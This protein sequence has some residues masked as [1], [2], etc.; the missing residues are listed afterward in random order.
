LTK[1]LFAKNSQPRRIRD[2]L[3]S[4]TSQFGNRDVETLLRDYT[5][6][7]GF[8]DVSEFQ[9]NGLTQKINAIC[10]NSSIKT[11]DQINAMS[12]ECYLAKRRKDGLSKQTSNHYRQ[13]I[14]QFCRW[15]VKHNYLNANPIS[16]VPKLNVKTDRRH[17]R[18]ALAP[19]EFRRLI[20]AAEAG[21]SIQAIPGVDRAMMYI[22]AAWTG[23]RRGEIGSLKL[24]SLDLESD[25]PTVTVDASFSKRRRKDTQ[26]LH[27]DVSERLKKWLEIRKP[28]HKTLLFPVSKVT[29][30][31]D[32]RTSIMMKRDLAI[33][34]Q[35][36][37]AEAADEA[38]R[39]KRTKSDFLTYKNDDGLFADFHANRHTFITNLGRAGLSAKV[40]QTLA[41]HSDIRLTMNVYSHT[42]LAEQKEAVGRLPQ[43]EIK[44]RQETPHEVENDNQPLEG[45]PQRL[46]Q[47]RHSNAQQAEEGNLGLLLTVSGK[48][49][50]SNSPGLESCNTREITDFAAHGSDFQEKIKVGS[51]GFEPPTLG[52]EDRCSIQLSY[53][54]MILEHRQVPMIFNPCQ[55]LTIRT[56][57]TSR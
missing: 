55:I 24:S 21:R 56:R 26:V 27:P 11:I 1:A 49:E 44:P 32:R 23:Y 35:K 38:E 3:V 50:E 48:I 10:S 28:I 12:V 13:A 42:D 18:R 19:D 15:L 14:H 33:A 29:C 52:S 6:Q 47:L 5:V 7:L 43:L 31:F 17:D 9:I 4:A 30:G 51:E 37:I 16:D 8:R 34:R 39:I 54:P 40:V 41:R 25:T 45:A 53:E 46:N 2:G 36:W 20:E 57:L 22:L